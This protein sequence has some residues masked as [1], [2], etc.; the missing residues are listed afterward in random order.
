MSMLD[1]LYSVGITYENS[2]VCIESTGHYGQNLLVHLQGYGF[3]V[4]VIN[5]LLTKA[6][7]KAQSVRKVKNDAFDSLALAKWLRSENPSSYTLPPSKMLELKK[8]ARFRTFL[9]QSISEHKNKVI[10]I[11]DEIFPEYEKLF[12]DIF[13]KASIAILLR[14]P[15][16]EALSRARLSTLTRILKENSGGRCGQEK[17]EALKEAAYSSFGTSDTLQAQTFELACLIDQI[18]NI[19]KKREEIDVFTKELL[20]QAD[21]H[22][23]TIPGIG[24]VCAATI[25]GEIGCISRFSS[26]SKLVAYA[27]LDSSVY[28]SGEF[29]GSKGSPSKRGSRYLRRALYLAA[30]SARKYDPCLSAYYEKKRSEGRSH[31]SA[32]C[33]V[34]RKLCNIIYAV[35][36]KDV[37]Y[38]CQVS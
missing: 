1:K 21:T 2:R 18:Q 29:K 12:S 4:A 19:Q 35:L 25:L 34:A 26:S 13:G 24:I 10:A 3:E 30:D 17:A 37:P 28:E 33:T 22:I 9:S 5:P 8:I 36:K 27:G 7:Q 38:T 31:R 16:P 15:S 6:Y 11:L 20:T 32:V 23:T 14:Y